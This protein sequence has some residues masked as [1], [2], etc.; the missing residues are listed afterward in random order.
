[1]LLKNHGFDGST[2]LSDWAA[3]FLAHMRSA[4]PDWD[5][6]TRFDFVGEHEILPLLHDPG[7][8]E[9]LARLLRSRKNPVLCLCTNA[10]P[11]S[12]LVKIAQDIWGEGGFFTLDWDAGSPATADRAAWPF[13]LIEQRHMSRKDTLSRCYRISMLCGRARAHRLDLWLA[14]RDLIVPQD[15]VVM[16]SFGLA[17]LAYDLP[18]ACDLPWSNHPG[19]IDYVNRQHLVNVDDTAGTV[20]PAFRACVN[21]TAESSGSDPGI[22]ITEKTWKSLQSGCMTWHWPGSGI[23]RYLGDLGFVNWFDNHDRAPELCAR[24]LFSRSDIWQLYHDNRDLVQQDIELFWS[25]D[26]LQHMAR[27]ALR[28]LESWLSR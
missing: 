5:P 27:P 25:Q 23:G 9:H 7:N 24:D 8:S 26:L 14:V 28:S 6:A 17:H 21:I 11:V 15:M 16:N 4:F 18:P 1:M 13:F 12:S 10:V 20:H 2:Q 19:H 3:Y 22:F